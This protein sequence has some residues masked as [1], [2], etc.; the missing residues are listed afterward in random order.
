MNIAAFLMDVAPLGG[1][2]AVLGGVAF[3]L[4]LAAVAFIA[5]LLLRKTLKMA[6]RLVIVAVILAIA[7]IGC[8]SFA[9]LGSGK[10]P[11]PGPPRPGP[12]QPK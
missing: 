9:W 3:F 8:V 10:T 1:G 5:F 2:I 7:I 12:V 6:F 4:V 11:R